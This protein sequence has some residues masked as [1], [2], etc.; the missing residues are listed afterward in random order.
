MNDWLGIV[1][2]GLPRLTIV[3]AAVG[4]MVLAAEAQTTADQA[5]GHRLAL[6]ICSA[7]HIVASDQKSPPVL[8][9][10]AP[11]FHSIAARPG[12]SV[13]SLQRFIL[14]THA[15]I[16]TPAGMPNPRLTEGQ[17]AEIAA[18]IVSLHSARSTAPK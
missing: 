11:D 3:P 15:E 12:S 16:A 5:E 4:S 6:T 9:D 18:Y 1:M 13:A 8:R 2:R 14:T 7:C 10:P 17:A